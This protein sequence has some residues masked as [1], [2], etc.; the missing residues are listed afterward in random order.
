MAVEDMEMNFHKTSIAFRTVQPQRL[1]ALGNKKL[2]EGSIISTPGKKYRTPL[3]FYTLTEYVM[4]EL[5]SEGEG[6]M[7]S[8][9]R[10]PVE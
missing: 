8:L 10:L 9:I 6:N 1:F 3:Y 5:P 2:P 4:R 7:E